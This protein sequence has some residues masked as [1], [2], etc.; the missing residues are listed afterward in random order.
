MPIE[1]L[2]NEQHVEVSIHRHGLNPVT[3]HIRADSLTEAARRVLSDHLGAEAV[4]VHPTYE[5]D[6]AI[7]APHNPL[8]SVENGNHAPVAVTAEFRDKSRTFRVLRLT[9][10][11]VESHVSDDMLSDTHRELLGIEED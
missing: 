5:A 10:R 8:A 1:N 7:G 9:D 3:D 6:P 4:I 2:V 11:A